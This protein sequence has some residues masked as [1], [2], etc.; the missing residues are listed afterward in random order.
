MPANVRLEHD[1]GVC[2]AVAGWHRK[3]AVAS[4]YRVW[5]GSIFN[6]MAYKMHS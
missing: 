3:A 5:V 2:T 6:K 4:G 1:F